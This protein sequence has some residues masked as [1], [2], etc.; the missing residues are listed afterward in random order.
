MLLQM[1]E[2][3][4]RSKKK[5]GGN[6]RAR[7]HLFSDRRH[8]PIHRGCISIVRHGTL[9]AIHH[10]AL[11]VLCCYD[12]SFLFCACIVHCVLRLSLDK[13]SCGLQI[14]WLKK[15]QNP[16]SGALLIFYPLINP[17]ALCSKL[18][19]HFVPYDLQYALWGT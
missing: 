19:K 16:L 15:L 5:D 9:R 18:K 4:G 11:P 3:G 17:I 2:G 10:V 6:S 8:H 7:P 13:S 1:E 12:F 14:N